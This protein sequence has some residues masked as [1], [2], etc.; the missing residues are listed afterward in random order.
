MFSWRHLGK[1]IWEALLALGRR[2]RRRRQRHSSPV[3]PIEASHGPRSAE[4]VRQAYRRMLRVARA[5]G[6]GR[7]ANETT[8]ELEGRLTTTLAARPAE[9][10]TALTYL[11]KRAIRRDRSQRGRPSPCDHRLG[12]RN[13]PPFISNRDRSLTGSCL[14]LL[15]G[16]FP[17]GNP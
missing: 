9:A 10:L 13:G 16:R 12:P 14:L 4:N 7:Q 5:S 6:R 15:L 2:L 3:L 8:Q 17:A 1:Q 11:Y